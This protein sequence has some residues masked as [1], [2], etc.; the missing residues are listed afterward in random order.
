MEEKL[1][2]SLVIACYNEAGHLEDSIRQILKIMATTKYKY[3]IIFVDDGSSD[4]TKDIIC[5]LCNNNKMMSYVFHERN[6][7]RGKSVSD[8]IKRAK[9]EVVGF[10][11]ID[12]ET[13]AMYIPWLVAEV[14]GGADIAYA[15]RI[16]I[17][18]LHS[19]DRW[20]LNRGY[21]FLVRNFLGLRLMDTEA[22]F[23]F[24]NR[25]KILSVLEKVKDSH[26]FWDTEIIARSY[27]KGL[28]IIEVPTLY[29]R[30]RSKKST[31]KIF[32]DTIYYF[33]KLLLFKY[34]LKKSKCHF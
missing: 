34:E 17:R 5:R 24:F 13:H 10:M 22:G 7:G 12:L 29:V 31:V 20:I 25:E 21:N 6:E 8:G 33:K 2:L 18:K 28:K 23:K 3:E 9:G 32:K 1:D 19:L 15:W 16:Y 27:F 4:G 30:N 11:D 26:W 14:L